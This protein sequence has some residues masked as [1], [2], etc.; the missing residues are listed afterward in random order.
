MKILIRLAMLR[1]YETKSRG[2]SCQDAMSDLFYILLTN[3]E[4]PYVGGGRDYRS[5]L[6]NTFPPHLTGGD[7]SKLRDMSPATLTVMVRV[8][9]GGEWRPLWGSCGKAA[10]WMRKPA[11]DLVRMATGGS[12]GPTILSDTVYPWASPHE[13]GVDMPVESI[14]SVFGSGGCMD[15]CHLVN[16]CRV[17]RVRDEKSGGSTAEEPSGSTDIYV[18]AHITRTRAREWVSS[19]GAGQCSGTRRAVMDT[20]KNT[21]FVAVLSTF[22][23]IKKGGGLRCN[24]VHR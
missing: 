8:G 22:K 20:R 11:R 1:K 18:T 6:E 15:P 17:I 2:G 10:E 13:A 16:S 19:Q 3:G 14:S 9:V 24:V 12:G 7:P 5:E 21:D 23:G 4:N